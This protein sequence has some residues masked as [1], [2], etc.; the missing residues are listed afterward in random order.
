MISVMNET[1]LIEY[2]TEVLDFA[3][4]EDGMIVG[5]GRMNTFDSKGN[6]NKDKGL[7]L[8]MKTGEV[9]YMTIKQ[10]SY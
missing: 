6:I 10:A 1:K 4:L 5:I 8:K 9:F 2:I 3:S 7:V